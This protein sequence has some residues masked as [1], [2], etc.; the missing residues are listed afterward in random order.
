LSRVIS[1]PGLFAHVRTRKIIANDDVTVR[2]PAT[3]GEPHGFPVASFVELP[4]DL[5]VGIKFDDLP[6]VPRVTRR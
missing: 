1:G 6:A 4:N 5:Q 3:G 2:Q